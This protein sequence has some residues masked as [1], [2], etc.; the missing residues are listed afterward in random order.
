[1]IFM[2]AGQTLECEASA[3]TSLCVTVY[4]KV[5][6][7]SSP[8]NWSYQRVGFSALTG[9]ATVDVVTTCPSG[10]SYEVININVANSNSSARAVRVWHVDSGD[11]A[12]S[13]NFIAYDATVPGNG[14]LTINKD[15]VSA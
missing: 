13:D 10:S 15:G 2:T 8:N 4:A 14:A 5:T 11:A 7:L 12:G 1:M 3:A 9:A 6:P